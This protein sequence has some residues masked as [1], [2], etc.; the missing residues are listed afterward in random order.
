M[1]EAELQKQ[2]DLFKDYIL[3]NGGKEAD[4]WLMQLAKEIERTVR[5]KA[6]NLAQKLAHGIDALHEG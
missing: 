3:A 5:H 1:N 4:R 6:V 2:I